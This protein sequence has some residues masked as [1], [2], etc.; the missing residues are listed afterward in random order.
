MIIIKT[1]AEIKILKE[2]GKRLA[3]VLEAVKQKVLKEWQ[4]GLT[5]DELDVYATKLINEMGD[6]P[7]FLNYQPEGASIPYPRSL[8]V[9]I[10]HQIVH[11]I[12]NKKVIIKEGDIVSLDL[13]L[14]HGGLFT[15]HAVSIVV[16]KGT[17]R[18]HELVDA[19]NGALLAGISMA[20]AGNRIGDISYA[21]EQYLKP[22]KV[23]IYREISGHGV[24][25]YIHEDPYIPNYGKRGTGAVLKPGMVIAIEPMIG[26]GSIKTVIESD[27]YTIS[28][29]DHSRA[30]H[31]EHTVL[32]TEGEPEI[33]TKV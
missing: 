26:S 13:G 11:G 22:Y 16:G 1:P 12:P 15:D 23:A 8:C 17:K 18:D 32:I 3:T 28:T 2:G 24:G 20:V 30:A 7:A 29:L 27:G 21:I 33:L 9:S 4:N 14:K 10:N 19:A 25:R 6:I 31:A 5:T